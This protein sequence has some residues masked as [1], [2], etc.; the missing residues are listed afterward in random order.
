MSFRTDLSP[1]KTLVRLSTPLPVFG[2]MIAAGLCFL[3]AT[4]CAL[5]QESESGSSHRVHRQ[6]AV[7]SIPM[8]E[9]TPA[10][11]SKIEEIVN[12]PSMYRR[13]P[14]GSILS[15][16]DY[17]QFF[18]RY[19]EVIVSIWQLMGVTQMTTERTGPFTLDT[20]DG[21]GTLGTLELVYGNDNFHIYY[22]T[23]V[24]QGPIF[25]RKLNG[26]CVLLL[27]SQ[28]QVTPNGQTQ[29]VSQMDV[30][31]KMENVGTN[32]IAKTLQPLIGPTADQNFLDS[33]TF[34]QRLQEKT[35]ENGPG[36]QHMGTRLNIDNQVRDRFIELAGTVYQRSQQK[37]QGQVGAL[38]PAAPA[39]IP[40][41]QS[42]YA[43]YVDRSGQ[44]TG[45]PFQSSMTSG[46]A[47]NNSGESV[48]RNQF[49]DSRRSDFTLGNSA[50]NLTD[51]DKPTNGNWNRAASDRGAEYSAPQYRNTNG[52]PRR[53]PN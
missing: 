42:A 16:P 31:L 6:Q 27:R 24:Y 48:V 26:R 38:S 29:I 22:G 25:K 41:S 39:T 18:V 11:Q 53:D 8:Q 15:D 17:F 1:F 37:Q 43:V 33:L 20:D 19:P 50:S 35:E 13:L 51:E 4:H 44:T 52:F 28:Q 14:A 40:G 10:A 34:L 47:G 2:S 23:G 30:F 7:Q 21:S 5:G 9:L 46:G 12:N 45:Q 49:S 3:L 32:L 36:V